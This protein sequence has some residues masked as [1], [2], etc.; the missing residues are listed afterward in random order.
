MLYERV[1]EKAESYVGEMGLKVRAIR[2]VCVGGLL[3]EQLHPVPSLRFSS[4]RRSE[5]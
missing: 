5:L 1:S 2:C 3:V 4:I